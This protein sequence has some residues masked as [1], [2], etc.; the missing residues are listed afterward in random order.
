MRLRLAL[1]ALGATFCKIRPNAFHTP[2]FDSRW[3][4]PMNSQN[5]KTK[6][7]LLRLQKLKTTLQQTYDLPINAVFAE[8]DSIAVAS[9][10]VAQ[11]HFATLLDG[12]EVA[13]KVLRP[14]IAKV[15]HKDLQ[16][17]DTASL[18][19]PSAFCGRQAFKTAGNCGR[20]CKP[21]RAAS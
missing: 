19:G 9:A 3:T 15:I 4:L 1:E 2:R 8:F 21:Y 16:L 17:L 11:V 7:R 5:C 14:N 12:K 6:C 13:V 20:I 10:S 18:V